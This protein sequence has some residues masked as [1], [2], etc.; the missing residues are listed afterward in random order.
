M[1]ELHCKILGRFGNDLRC[2]KKKS[3]LREIRF[4]TSYVNYTPYQNINAF[5]IYVY[6]LYIII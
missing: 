2:K 4:E 5:Y 6:I 3:K 1:S